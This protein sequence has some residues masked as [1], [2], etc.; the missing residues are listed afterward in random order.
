[1]SG[2]AG[3]VE[4]LAAKLGLE[5]EEAGFFKAA[6]LLHV[7]E[8]V[9]ETVKEV[10]IDTLKELAALPGETAKFAREM[11][12]AAQRTGTSVEAFQELAFA[13]KDVG[14]EA[15][16]LEHSLVLM[17]RAAFGASEGSG[18]M[19][20]AFK[21][22]GVQ[23]KDADGHIRPTEELLTDFAEKF[24][25]LPDGPEKTALAMRAFGRSGA[26]MIPLLN[27][28]SEGIAKL[29]EE[30]HEFGKVLDGETLEAAERFR[31]N[32][33]ALDE[34]LEGL[35]LALG[36]ELLKVMGDWKR[37]LAD[38]INAIRPHVVELFGAA[39]SFL[40][41][42]V[43]GLLPPLRLVWSVLKLLGRVVSW[44]TEEVLGGLN[45]LVKQLDESFDGLG[46]I[47]KDVAIGAALAWAAAAAPI[48]LITGLVIGLLAVLE[49]IETFFE[50]GDSYTGDFLEAIKKNWPKVTEFLKA[51][52]EAFKDW[53]V[54]KAKDIGVGIKDAIVDAL[55]NAVAFW[56]NEFASIPILG[57]LMSDDKKPTFGGGDAPGAQ[58]VVAAAGAGGNNNTSSFQVQQTINVGPNA[59]PAEIGRASAESLDEWHGALLSDAYAGVGG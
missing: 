51:E 39:I 43:R 42:M 10:A 34:S 13:A 52:W 32:N 6:A 46:T 18:E 21:K 54:Q 55:K 8:Q 33:L 3:Y 35:K 38:I 1:M 2:V 44:L 28:G 16:D 20:A 41:I 23:V 12:V 49:D 59:S 22:L 9:L 17:S 15:S 25:E 57:S 37:Q 4:E 36:G 53:L 58:A 45:D 30:A 40:T 31:K 19:G 11:T 14:I 56:K 48:V 47:M 29:R 24:K 26:Q 27:Q 50:G 7:V 5:T